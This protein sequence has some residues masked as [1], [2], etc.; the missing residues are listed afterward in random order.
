MC[1][2]PAGQHVSGTATAGVIARP[3]L[4]FL[5][6]L[7]LGLVSDHMLPLP[8]AV[9][10][11]GLVHWGVA[12]SLFLIGLALMS[13]GARN[14]SRAGTPVPTVEPVRALVTTGIH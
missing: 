13:A 4:I 1:S 7:L 9:P 14:F 5:A 6:A 10:G 12:G 2:T 3:P 8:I 11:T